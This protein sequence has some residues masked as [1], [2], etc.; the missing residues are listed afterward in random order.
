M[1]SAHA[2]V[3]LAECPALRRI[4]ERAAPLDAAVLTI[5]SEGYTTRRGR[6]MRAIWLR[7]AMA[8]PPE[9]QLTESFVRYVA[10]EMGRM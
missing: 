5:W 8:M 7:H 6:A 10:A 1:M 4:V 2:P 9:P 3:A